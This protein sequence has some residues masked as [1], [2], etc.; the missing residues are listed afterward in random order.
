M[1]VEGNPRLPLQLGHQIR[2]KRSGAT[3]HAP[4]FPLNILHPSI[5]VTT[6]P[7]SVA[8]SQAQ[9]VQGPRGG[10]RGQTLLQPV[11]ARGAGGSKV[12]RFTPPGERGCGER[13]EREL[14]PPGKPAGRM[15]R[16]RRG[17]GTKNKKERNLEGE[18]NPSQ[19]NHVFAQHTPQRDVPSLLRGD[20]GAHGGRSGPGRHPGRSGTGPAPAPQ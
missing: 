13:A 1:G 3:S 7:S 9:G 5:C 4:Q 11:S 8:R 14:L 10:V 6:T 12:P 18:R 20:S 16:P 2:A 15:G 17:L 19:E